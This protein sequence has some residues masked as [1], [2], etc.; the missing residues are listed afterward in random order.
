MEQN[1]AIRYGQAIICNS[2]A[3]YCVYCLALGFWS[4]IQ[5][6]S[7]SNRPTFDKKEATLFFAWADILRQ[8]ASCCNSR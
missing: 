4:T 8:N 1:A 3:I 7:R 5:K 2:Y 6:D